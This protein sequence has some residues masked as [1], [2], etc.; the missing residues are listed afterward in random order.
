MIKVI[1]INLYF[2]E[3]G[4]EKQKDFVYGYFVLIN[5]FAGTIK[6]KHTTYED[7]I[8]W[9]SKVFERLL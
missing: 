5:N 4:K 2:I 1:W 7:L 9:A 6:K 8:V 3:E